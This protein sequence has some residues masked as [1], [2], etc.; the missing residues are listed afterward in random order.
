[1]RLE[2]KLLKLTYRT[3]MKTNE[4]IKAVPYC[5]VSSREQEETGYSLTQNMQ[6]DLALRGAVFKKAMVPFLASILE[7]ELRDE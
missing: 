7:E 6:G 4:K 2:R 3:Y 1:M 5:R